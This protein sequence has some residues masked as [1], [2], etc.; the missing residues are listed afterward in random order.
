[1]LVSEKYRFLFRLTS[2]IGIVIL[3]FVVPPEEE[4]RRMF[5]AHG[6]TFHPYRSLRT[7]Y[8]I[9]TNLSTSS[10]RLYG[11]ITLKP[12]WITDSIAAGTLLNYRDYL[13][14]DLNE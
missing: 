7:N 2:K 6:G 4:L 1:M 11:S 14:Y 12:E 8:V 5:V 13:L 9:A 3:L 10:K